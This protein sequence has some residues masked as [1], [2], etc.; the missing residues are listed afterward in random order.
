M[1]AWSETYWESLMKTTEQST[2]DSPSIRASD[3][4]RERTSTALHA[5]AASGMLTIAEVEERLSTVYTSKFRHELD[6][7]V[8]DLPIEVRSTRPGAERGV[9]DSARAAGAAVVALILTVASLAGRHRRITAVIVLVLAAVFA[10][11]M[12]FGGTEMDG[13]Q[14]YGHQMQG[15]HSTDG[16]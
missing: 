16:N 2:S 13:H 1:Y 10:A 3:V 7:Q 4:D 9:V 5:A 6:A 14:M 15:A 11:L 8:A 12:F